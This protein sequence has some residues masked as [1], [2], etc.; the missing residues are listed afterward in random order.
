MAEITERDVFYYLSCYSWQCAEEIRSQIDGETIATRNGIGRV[1]KH[2][3][4]IVEKGFA[5]ARE[6]N[7]LGNNKVKYKL[8]KE[9]RLT[10]Y[11]ADS[12]SAYE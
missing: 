11:G 9:Y 1:K 3:D 6:R 7:L 8:Q 5:E 12:Y 2:L 10:E 4:S